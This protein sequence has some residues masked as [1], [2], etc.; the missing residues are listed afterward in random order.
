MKK[1]KKLIFISGTGRSGTHL[2]GRSLSSHPEVIGRIEDPTTFPIITRL[3]TTQDI[4]NYLFNLLLRVRLKNKLTTIL[5]NASS[6][7]L[8]KSHP[9]LWLVD[10]LIKEIKNVFFIFVY[11]D[12]EPTVSSMLEHN[13]VLSWYSNLPQNKVNRFLGI[14]K[15]NVKKFNDLSL[16]EKCALRWLSHKNEILRLKNKYPEKILTIRYEEFMLAPDSFYSEV[17]QF[18]DITN[19]FSSEKF[20]TDS[21]DKWK[22]KLNKDQL[23]KIYKAV[24]PVL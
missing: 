8:E 24:N 19:S 18:L 1:P 12:V 13:G 11:R 23:E 2:I 5:N 16:E 17:S 7:V 10:Y 9:S 21:L 6:H 20:K 14:N 4:N 15:S 22:E 3:A